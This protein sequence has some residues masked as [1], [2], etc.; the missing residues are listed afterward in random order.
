[1]SRRFIL[2]LALGTAL[3]VSSL[4]HAEEAPDR[5]LRALGRCALAASIYKSLLPPATPPVSAEPTDA[6]KAL[7]KQLQEVE[8]T[9]RARAD[10]LAETVDPVVRDGIGKELTEQFYAQMAPKDGPPKTPR[11][12]LDLYA[13]ILEAC[14]VRANMLSNR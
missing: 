8:P 10:A 7:Y 4:A 13:P 12:A 9:L 6:D 11:D 2:S 3:A 1:M 14:V 5:E